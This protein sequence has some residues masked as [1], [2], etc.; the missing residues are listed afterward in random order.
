MHPSE[1]AL[2]YNLTTKDIAGIFK[3]SEDYVRDLANAGTIPSVRRV[4]AYRFNLEEVTKALDVIAAKYESGN[5]RNM[6][7]NTPARGRGEQPETR[8]VEIEK[9]S[10]REHDQRTDEDEFDDIDLGI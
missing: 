3:Y 10:E 8:S 6:K 4:R 5:P 7:K 1:K 9:Y 2:K